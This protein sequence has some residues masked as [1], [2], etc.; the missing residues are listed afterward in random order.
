MNYFFKTISF[1]ALIVCFTTACFSQDF[2]QPAG[3]VSPKELAI[4]PSPVFDLMGAT[5]TQ[6][7]RMADIK[8][9]KVDWSLKYGVNPNLAIQSQPFWELFYN[10]KDLSRYQ[11]ASGFMRKL[12]SIDISLG[13][14]Q[15]DD[16]Y[17]RIGGAV[18][19]NVYRQ[20]DPLLEK[21]LYEDI[22]VRYK[23]EKEELLIQLQEAKQKLD[24]LT[25]ILEK[26]G[27]RMQ[28]RSLEEQLNSQHSRRV[29]EINERAKIFVNEYWNASSL[30]VAVGRMYTFKSDSSGTFG[31]KRSDR[32][33]GIGIWLNG[34]L[35][36]GRQFLMTGL[37]RS[38]WYNEQVDFIVLDNIT[39][40]ETADKTIARN[41]LYS[42]GLNLRYGGAVY[43][44]FV[45]LLYEYKKL[46]TAIDAVNQY[47][48]TP[49]NVQIIGSSLKWDEVHP[50]TLSF[51]GDWR[52]S[53]S[54][55]I[56]YGM[57]CVFD[58]QWSFKAFIPVAT[59]SCMMR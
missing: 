4:S 42:M 43:T 57:R 6:V 21:G 47:Y 11:N 41:N 53:Q 51:G 38:L 48:K 19:L 23:Q 52:I 17:R 39:G 34:N 18:K 33:T 8:D 40:N 25:N 28:I 10:R 31:M 1:E 29:S 56:N 49:G 37:L 50:N 22:G 5:P 54:V 16:S 9:F 15:D 24:T 44:F 46:N 58:N 20:K 3:R 7:T 13:S 27:L 30:D 14:I 2:Q 59:I 36:I 45:E 55:I 26:P 32:S 35:G 12:A